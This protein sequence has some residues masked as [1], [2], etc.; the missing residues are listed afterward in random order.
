[1]IKTITQYVVICDN[2][3]CDMSTRIVVDIHSD[4]R[5][6]F[7]DKKLKSL[8]WIC[9]EEPDDGGCSKVICPS[10]G[11]FISESQ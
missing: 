4:N 2:A 6:K 3:F 5:R 7:F 10:C 11:V 8:G 1:M 9:L